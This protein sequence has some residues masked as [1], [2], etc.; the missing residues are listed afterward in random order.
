MA[1]PI[2]IPVFVTEDD[3]KC[4]GHTH[5]VNFNHY[6]DEVFDTKWEGGT[7]FFFS[8]KSCMLEIIILR[9]IINALGFEIS[10]VHDSNDRDVAVMTTYPW[11]KSLI[12]KLY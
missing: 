10:D 11:Q 2:Q 7:Y 3:L 12:D 1:T 6:D 8:G 5:C 4:L 9:N